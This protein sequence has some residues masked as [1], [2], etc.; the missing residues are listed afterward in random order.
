MLFSSLTFLFAFLPLCLVAYYLAPSKAR[1]CVLLAA[2]LLFYAWGEGPFVAVMLASIV[3]NWSGGLA[4]HALVPGRAR[5]A[6]MTV[7]VAANLLLLGTFKY[8]NFFFGVIVHLPIGI[9]FFTFHGLSYLI[10]VYRAK[11]VPERSPLRVALYI[12]LFPQLIAGPIIRYADI[13]G[14]IRSRASNLDSF[15]SGIQRFAIGL[16]KKVLLANTLA[17]VA[18][19]C[20]SH[21]NIV[22][23][24]SNAW[25]GLVAYSLQI[26]FDFSGYSDMAIGLAKMFGFNFPENFN[27]PYV[28][29]S[30]TEFWRRWHISLSTWFRDYLYIPLGGNRSGPFRTYVHLGIVFLLCGLWHGAS[31]NFVIWGAVHGG[32]LVVERIVLKSRLQRLPLPLSFLANLYTLLVVMLAWVFFRTDS[33]AEAYVYLKALFAFGTAPTTFA[34]SLLD[35]KTTTTFAVAIGAS[36]PVVP[37]LRSR[38][39]RLADKVVWQFLT[40]VGAVAVFWLAVF[41]LAA[42]THNPFIY[43]RF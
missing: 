8:A 29:R 5:V 35:L 13:A 18:D 10:D 39:P 6:L 34:M 2:S 17:Q 23:S 26:Y 14:A 41:S 19:R 9:S 27:F 37:W 40:A 25:L 30:I 4:V 31:W 1:N 3:L 22:L 15:A 32:F 11:E 36:L 20:F 38:F 33:L 42:G 43:F 21:E 28:A 16:G 24:A 7:A 12:A